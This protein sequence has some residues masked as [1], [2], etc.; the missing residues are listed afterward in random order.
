MASRAG[1]IARRQQ[2][3]IT[4]S[5]GWYSVKLQL[6]FVLEGVRG[7][8]RLG[9][10]STAFDRFSQAVLTEAIPQDEKNRSRNKLTP[11]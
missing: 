7:I 5:R 1:R 6:P 11:V 4:I 3:R 9:T 2:K 8:S 10:P